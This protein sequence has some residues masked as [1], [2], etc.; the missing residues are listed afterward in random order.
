MVEKHD[1]KIW[2]ESKIGEGSKFIF[3]IPQNKLGEMNLPAA[4]SGVS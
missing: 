3:T 4:S 1:G 2:V